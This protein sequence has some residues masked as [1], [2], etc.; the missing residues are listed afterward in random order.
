MGIE[1]K[2]CTIVVEAEDVVFVLYEVTNFFDDKGPKNDVLKKINLTNGMAKRK[3]RKKASHALA[4]VGTG[5]KGAVVKITISEINFV[6]E[7]KVD[8]DRRLSEMLAFNVIF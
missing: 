5:R 4:I 6:E 8:S 2:E 3:F 1:E 7:V